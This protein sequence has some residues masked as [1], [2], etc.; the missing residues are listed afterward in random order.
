MREVVRDLVC[1]ARV[2]ELALGE[3]NELVE[4]GNDVA[5]RLVNGEDDRAVVLASQ[6]H[7]T[8]DNTERVVRIQT[9][10]PRVSKIV[11]SE[12]IARAH[13]DTYH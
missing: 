8:V 5:A 10:T 9:C 1:L 13:M 7:E 12:Y 3:H 11:R 6:R 4:E 2:D